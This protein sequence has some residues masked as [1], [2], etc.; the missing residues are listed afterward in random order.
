M[1]NTNN[2]NNTNTIQKPISVI[3]DEARQTIVGAINSTELHVALLKPIIKDL[4]NEISRQASV[5]LEHERAEYQ[6]L[7]AEQQ[8]LAEI[9]Q[10][11]EQEQESEED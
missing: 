7:I 10:E 9:E 3:L 4:Y 2:I 1:N 6:R 11:Q 5:Q 8:R